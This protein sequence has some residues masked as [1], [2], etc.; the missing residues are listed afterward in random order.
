MSEAAE[1]VAGLKRHHIPF[2]GVV[3]NRMVWD[4]FALEERAAVDAL[5]RDKPILGA[6]TL[7]RIDRAKAAVSRLRSLS[8]PVA[9]VG[10]VSA[11]GPVATHIAQTL[12]GLA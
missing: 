2:S 1:L 8:L 4:P 9:F 10:E 6:R 12:G 7:P 5:V 3:L 11:E